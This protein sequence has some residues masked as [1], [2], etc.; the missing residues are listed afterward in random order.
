MPRTQAATEAR[1]RWFAEMGWITPQAAMAAVN[2]GTAEKLVQSYELDIACAQ[3][4]IEKIKAGPATLFSVPPR[5]DPDK[6]DPA[7]GQMGAEVPGWMP[8]EFDNIS[9]HMQVLEDWMKTTDYET[10][11]QEVQHAADLYYGG[12]KQIKT[13]KEQEQAQAQAQ[14]AEGLGMA[15]AGK[16]QGAKPLP[17][18]P[19]IDQQAALGKGPGGPP[20]PMPGG[21]GPPP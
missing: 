19:G 16:P 20:P 21:P 17:N 7:T 8:R 5:F 1:V 4:V 11:P 14:M 10:A 6:V 2:G 15:N 13:E 9:V 12:L 18:R 3:R